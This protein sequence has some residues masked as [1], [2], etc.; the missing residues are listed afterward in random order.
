MFRESG[1]FF[2][3]DF[4]WAWGC[5]PKPM[6]SPIRLNH[7]IMNALTNTREG[8]DDGDHFNYFLFVCHQAFLILRKHFDEINVLLKLMAHAGIEQLGH[9]AQC[10]DK[11]QKTVK[12]RFCVGMTDEEAKTH[13]T[14]QIKGSIKSIMP[15]FMEF[16]HKYRF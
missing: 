4:G 3:I 14:A 10:E 15:E 11:I 7:D 13:L 5:D 9:G 8:D 12:S 6:P 1:H 2:H 16:C